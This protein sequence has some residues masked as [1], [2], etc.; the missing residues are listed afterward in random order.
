MI[1]GRVL[2]EIEGLGIGVDANDGW[3]DKR[4]STK[5]SKGESSFIIFLMIES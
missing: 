1:K 4:L 5:I 2:L 3:V